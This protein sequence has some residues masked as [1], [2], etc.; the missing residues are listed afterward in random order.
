MRPALANS[1]ASAGVAVLLALTSANG[2]FA[3]DAQF[4]NV[5]SNGTQI[6][7]AGAADEQLP[8][9]NLNSV[10]LDGLSSQAGK[11]PDSPL[12][13]QL[14]AARPN[15]DLVI[16]V[17]G[18][19]SGRDRV[20]YAQPTDREARVKPGALAAGGKQGANGAS[21]GASGSVSQSLRGSQ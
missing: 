3:E 5:E 1:L 21:D 6:A 18:C 13:R 10:P 15:E 2:A 19:F 11:G 4:E 12:I 14:M 16:C 17:A 8:A 9:K 20:V 7:A